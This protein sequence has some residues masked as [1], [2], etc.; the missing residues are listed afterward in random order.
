MKVMGIDPGKSGAIAV[1]NTTNNEVSYIRLDETSLDVWA[2]IEAQ[3]PDCAILERVS[4]MPRQGVSSTFKFGTSFGFCQG[5]LVAAR[6]PH[7]LVTPGEW[8]KSLRCLSKGDKNVT[9]SKAQELFPHIKITHKNADALLIAEYAR[10][11]AHELFS[12]AVSSE[13]VAV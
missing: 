1:I 2:F 8:Q 13:T 4:A 7:V 9:K 6:I 3:Q 12:L 10:R 11:N 5:V